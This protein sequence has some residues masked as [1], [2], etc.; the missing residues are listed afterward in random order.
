M[1]TIR[2]VLDTIMAFNKILV[3]YCVKR[4][5]VKDVNDGCVFPEE[6]PKEDA[7]EKNQVVTS[8]PQSGIR[9]SSRRSTPNS[10]YGSEYDT[11]NRRN[12]NNASSGNMDKGWFDRIRNE[13]ATV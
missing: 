1:E 9:R 2:E 11:G 3:E 13:K 12:E 7:S 10:F 8:M 4:L 5:T 6:S